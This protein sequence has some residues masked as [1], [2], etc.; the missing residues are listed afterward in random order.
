M[1]RAIDGFEHGRSQ[2]S[3]AATWTV[4]DH[5]PEAP[6]PHYAHVMQSGGHALPLSLPAAVVPTHLEFALKPFLVEEQGFL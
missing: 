4:A 5:R 1:T 3:K 2:T 6:K